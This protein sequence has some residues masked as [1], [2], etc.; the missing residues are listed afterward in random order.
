MALKPIWYVFDCMCGKRLVVV[1]R[2]MLPM[3]ESSG[4]IELT[5]PVRGK[6]NTISAA[7]IDR[8][9][10]HKRARLRLKGRTH[11][12]PGS[13]LKFSRWSQENFFKYLREQFNLDSLP[14]HDPHDLAPLDPDAQGLCAVPWPCKNKMDRLGQNV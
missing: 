11:T 1:L 2:T 4:E 8:L 12:K 5:A 3:L 10:P 6:L 9:L 7:T 13:L 14:T